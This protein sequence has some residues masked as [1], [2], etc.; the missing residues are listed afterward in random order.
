MIDING[1]RRAFSKGALVFDNDKNIV[2]YT[3]TDRFTH[4]FFDSEEKEILYGIVEACKKMSITIKHGD[5]I[6][7]TFYIDGN[8]DNTIFFSSLEEDMTPEE[9]QNKIIENYNPSE[10][11]TKF[12]SDVDLENEDAAREKLKEW[13]SII[14][15]ANKRKVR[16]VSALRKYPHIVKLSRKLSN[17]LA[18]TVVF[19]E[20]DDL[21]DGNVLFEVSEDLKKP[22]LLDKENK[23][24]FAEMVNISSAVEFEM[25]P[26]KGYLNMYFYS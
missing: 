6:K 7:F 10:E 21:Q 13:V 17:V 16:P 9:I 4:Q 11:F 12:M 15:E 19:T 23:K 22:I 25:S 20:P 24:M 26:G 8:F 14:N 3:L 18:S 2:M 1:I 5:L